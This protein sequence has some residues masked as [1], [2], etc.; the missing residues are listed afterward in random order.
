MM[1]ANEVR[2]VANLYT[3]LIRQSKDRA[4]FSVGI[5][6]PFVRQKKEIARALPSAEVS[7]IHGSQGREWDSVIF[8]PVG[9]HYHLTDSTQINALFGLNVA[10]SRIKKQLF[11][12][13]DRS[14]WQSKPT[15]FLSKLLQQAQI[16]HI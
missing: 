5:I 13:C 6:T 9:L 12:V 7:T 14:F 11:I 15:Q 4:N 8:S 2:A 16:L 1:S 3:H 10:I